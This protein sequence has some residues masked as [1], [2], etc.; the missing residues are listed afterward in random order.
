M[1]KFDVDYLSSGSPDFVKVSILN[2]IV[3]IVKYVSCLGKQIAASPDGINMQ[4]TFA[5]ILDKQ[6]VLIL[7]A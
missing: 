7:C 6:S 1:Y 2:I 3:N 5:E 4:I